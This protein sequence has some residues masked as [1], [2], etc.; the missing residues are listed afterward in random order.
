MYDLSD[1]SDILSTLDRILSTKSS[2]IK[3][4]YWKI[5]TTNVNVVDF[6]NSEFVEFNTF[7]DDRRLI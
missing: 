1:F 4:F 2:N 3:S 6:G 7:F 5:Q